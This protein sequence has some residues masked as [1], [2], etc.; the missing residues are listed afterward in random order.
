MFR[1][2]SACRWYAT[3]SWGRNCSGTCSMRD[4]LITGSNFGEGKFSLSSDMYEPE[5]ASLERTG[6]VGVAGMSSDKSDAVVETL[7]G[8]Q[9]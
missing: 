5:N 1:L 6:L 7:I 9:T 3:K 2:C 8:V 4:L